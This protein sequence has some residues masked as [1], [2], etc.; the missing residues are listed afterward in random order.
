M[1]ADVGNIVLAHSGE[2]AGLAWI[3]LESMGIGSGTKLFVML[4]EI[5]ELSGSPSA[6]F[7]PV[8]RTHQ[9]PQM[10]PQFESY[11]SNRHNLLQ[12][13]KTVWCRS[14]KLRFEWLSSKTSRTS[15]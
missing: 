12:N 3:T 14:L 9:D 4:D 1:Y 11:Y 13:Q 6:Q 15:F 5:N 10:P 8:Y 2:L 7:Y